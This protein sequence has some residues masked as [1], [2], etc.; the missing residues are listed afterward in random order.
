MDACNQN[1]PTTKPAAGNSRA[2]SGADGALIVNGSISGSPVTI[3]G[4]ALG[5]IGIISGAAVAV[6]SGAT[7]AP[8]PT[9]GFG[10]LTIRNILTL[11]AGSATLVP[12][13][14]SPLTNDAV[15]ISGTLFAGGTLFVA[16]SALD[17]TNGDSF[18]LFIAPNFSGNF[19]NII[20]PPLADRLF[21]NTNTLKTAGTIS[22]VA[23]TSPT[24]ANIQI[25]GANLV[26]SGTGGPSSWPY[27]VLSATNLTAAQWNSIATNQFDA[28]G[29]YSL[30][31]TNAVNLNQPQTFY[32]LQLQ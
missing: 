14:H 10:I 18:K 12:V 17:L 23:L 29:N 4:G 13:Q 26:I 22:V 9:A 31:V 11:A 7:L 8:G 32:Q 28:D 30:A 2:R 3:S 15:N 16:N 24:I 21:W 1:P 20:L 19:T 25:A 5:G 27:S 6:N